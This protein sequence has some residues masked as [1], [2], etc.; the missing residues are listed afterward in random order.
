MKNKRATIGNKYKSAFTFIEVLIALV[1][2]SI[3]LLGL[4]RLHLI[5]IN[6]TDAAQI[7]SQAVLLANE[8][9]AE[10]LAL[11]YPEEGIKAGTVEINALG[12]HWQ[13]EVTDI[14]A[15]QLGELDIEGLRRIL[16]N[17]SWE[18]GNRLKHIQMSTYVTDRKLP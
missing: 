12:L 2:V 9:I 16:V 5:S 14:E 13:T 18:Q 6:M 10:T 3:S 17:V 8:K 1:I 4:I 15:H 7:K 11:G